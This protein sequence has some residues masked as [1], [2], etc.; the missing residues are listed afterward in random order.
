MLEFRT[1]GGAE[2]GSIVFYVTSSGNLTFW[3]AGADRIL[4]NNTITLRKWTHVALVRSSGTTKMYVDGVAQTSTYSDSNDYGDGGRPLFIGVRRNGGSSLDNQ[5]WDGELSNVRIV[6]GTAVYTSNF[7][8]STTPLT[9]ISNTKLLC[10]QSTTSA[11][12]AAVTP[13][14]LLYTSDLPTKVTV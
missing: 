12:T 10:C 13:G 9:N 1:S 14:C 8:P 6:K 4:S 2:S 5:S 7:T 3:Y 11:T